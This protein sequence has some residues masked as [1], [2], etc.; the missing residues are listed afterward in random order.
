[1]ITRTYLKPSTHQA[2]SR[3]FAL[4]NTLALMTSSRSA[5]TVMPATL[6]ARSLLTPCVKRW[7][8]EA[9]DILTPPVSAANKSIG[10]RFELVALCWLSAGEV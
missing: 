7:C 10:R 1:M 3:G 4:I 9:A 8:S 6:R 2:S 5:P